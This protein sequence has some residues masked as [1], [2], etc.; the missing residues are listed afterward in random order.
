MLELFSSLVLNGALMCWCA[1][2]KLLSH[3]A[4]ES[5]YACFH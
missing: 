4:C 1:I 2:E 5:F 3:W